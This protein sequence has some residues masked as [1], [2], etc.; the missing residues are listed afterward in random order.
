VFRF[1]KKINDFRY[2][3]Y[4]Y[5]ITNIIFAVVFSISLTQWVNGPGFAVYFPT[6]PFA[7]DLTIIPYVFR[8]QTLVY[9]FVMSLVCVTCIYRYLLVVR[10]T[11][12]Q[13]RGRALSSLSFFPVT[14]WLVDTALIK[15]ADAELRKRINNLLHGRFRLDF[16]RIYL[17]ALEVRTTEFGKFKI[18]GSILTVFQLNLMIGIMIW[19]GIRIYQTIQKSKNSQRSKIVEKSALR[20]LVAQAINPIFLLHIPTFLNFLEAEIVVLPDMVNRISCVV[21][22]V[23]AVTN[24]L[25]NI[26]FSRNLLNSL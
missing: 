18:V 10:P 1:S 15:Q 6:G 12:S 8:M 3:F 9:L 24:P 13:L 23:F 4:T 11:S 5:C 22:N 2:V 14:L 19:A 20:L 7:S 16:E 17:F 21:M 25:L 26:I